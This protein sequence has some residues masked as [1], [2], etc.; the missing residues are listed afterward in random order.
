MDPRPI[1]IFDSG[2]GGLSIL[3]E[4]DQL[5]P[6]EHLLYFAD[7]AHIP[8]GQHSLEEIRQYSHGITTYLLEQGCKLI[9]V[10]CNSASAAALHELR[11]DFP[12][13][14]FVG[15]EPA[16]KPA[17]QA[18]R[19]GVIGVL[20]TPVTFQGELFASVVARYAA[21]VQVL[22]ESPLGLVG[23][24]EKGELSSAETLHILR[25]SVQPFLDHKADTIVLGCTHYPFIIPQLRQVTGDGVTIIDP[26]PAISRQ[27]HR[28]L[29]DQRMTAAEGT[30]GMRTFFT[31][32]DPLVLERQVKTLLG[33]KAAVLPARW[34]GTLL[35]EIER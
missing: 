28:L 24:I 17:V 10:A 23:K 30:H 31:S 27:V 13:I 26:A 15:M 22:Q 18:T 7:Q 1:G 33:W 12:D 25:K 9:V 34:T 2:V 3:R 16:V 35:T 20:A 5:L 4:I 29:S 14:P 32:A 6:A 8:Y 19:S 21:E 11:A